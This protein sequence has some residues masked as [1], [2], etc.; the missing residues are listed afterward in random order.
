MQSFA[1][2]WKLL[3][4]TETG[5]TSDKQYV[6][7]EKRQTLRQLAKTSKVTIHTCS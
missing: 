4:S 5:T 7:V 2:T 6:M 3:D 1:L